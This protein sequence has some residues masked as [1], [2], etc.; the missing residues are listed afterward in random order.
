MQREL[1]V[2]FPVVWPGG[3]KGSFGSLGVVA[4]LNSIA[5][6]G[7]VEILVCALQRFTVAEGCG[8]HVQD[9]S[10]STPSLVRH[11]LIYTL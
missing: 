7:I 4:A 2:H 10:P 8:A 3:C 11:S 6:L 1:L 9:D 5:K